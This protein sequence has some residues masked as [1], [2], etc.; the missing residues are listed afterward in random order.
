MGFSQ[1]KNASRGASPQPQKGPKM[2]IIGSNK[3]SLLFF[4]PMIQ[5][6]NEFW[7]QLLLGWI[8]LIFA[9]S[10]VGYV[11][12]CTLNMKISKI[13][14]IQSNF[15]PFRRI[16]KSII[17]IKKLELLFSE[18]TSDE[19]TYRNWMNSLGVNPRVNRIYGWVRFS[20]TLDLIDP[21]IQ[22]S[23]GWFDLASAGRHCK[24]G[25]CWLESS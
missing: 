9:F 20:R 14:K 6:I 19:R 11:S 13:L 2:I 15:Y 8:P 10:Y 3:C 24:T 22:W 4:Q 1:L 25:Y 5:W 7:C 23:D 17:R 16:R 18:E 12:V 21:F